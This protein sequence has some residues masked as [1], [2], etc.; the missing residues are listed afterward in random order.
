MIVA[1]E[2]P[3]Q[4]LFVILAFILIQQIEENVLMPLLSKRFIGLPPALV[5]ISLA[6]GAQFWGIMGA[7]L[8]IPLAGI[9]FE[10][11]RDFLKK[12]REEKVVVI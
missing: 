12:R 4:A 3:L 7:I 8:A 6:I 10:F 5:L 9:L 2:S 11:L 1:L